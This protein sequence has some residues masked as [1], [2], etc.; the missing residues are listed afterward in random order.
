VMGFMNSLEAFLYSVC[1]RSR[2]ELVVNTLARLL[3]VGYPVWVEVEEVVACIPGGKL[4]IVRVVRAI[5]LRRL[6]RYL[7]RWNI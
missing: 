1:D 3:G 6:S 5:Y 4:W 2:Q 7:N